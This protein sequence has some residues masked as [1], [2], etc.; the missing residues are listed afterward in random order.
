MTVD[1]WWSHLSD[2]PVAE[3][4]QILTT[5]ETERATRYLAEDDRA[6]FVLGAALA[7]ITVAGH[8]GHHP[9]DVPLARASGASGR[10]Y[11]PPRVRWL[12]PSVSVSISHA[13]QLVVAAVSTDAAVGVDV[14]PIGART[15]AVA[16][17][18]LDDVFSAGERA[19]LVAHGSQPEHVFRL[20]TRK[21]AVV[22]ATQVGLTSSPASVRV[23][24]DGRPA[25]A[26]WERF[27]HLLDRVELYD[28][29]PCPGY[30]GALAIL[31]ATRSRLSRVVEH[32]GRD[33][34]SRQLIGV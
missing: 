34:L 13:G 25:F 16:M 1:I 6:R 14:E 23:D 17:V 8:T 18:G 9:R 4:L 21:E 7:R 26:G 2:G 10:D 29:D 28:L 24:V 3:M 19:S 15:D 22:K 11:G 31:S 20:W 5:S 33:L 12:A 27:P 32:S 30:V